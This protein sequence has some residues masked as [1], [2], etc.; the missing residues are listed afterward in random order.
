M[1]EINKLLKKGYL[2]CFSL[3]SSSAWEAFLAQASEMMAVAALHSS[4]C[5][6][7]MGGLTSILLFFASLMLLSLG[8]SAVART[9][10]LF[11]SHLLMGTLSA[12]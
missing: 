4:A 10:C 11:L 3:S 6:C 8:S 7:L 5:P 9:A 12:Y 1:M 2:L